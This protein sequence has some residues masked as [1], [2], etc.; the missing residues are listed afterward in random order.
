MA[1]PQAPAAGI[2]ELTKPVCPRC[3]GAV[4][5]Y[6]RYRKG[7]RVYLYAVHV[8]PDSGRRRK[9]YL[10]PVDGYV[11]ARTTHP[12]LSLRGF[13]QDVELDWDRRVDYVVELL[14]SFQNCHDD[15]VLGRLLENLRA[16][17]EILE[18]RISRV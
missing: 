12:M 11:H 1:K 10:G 3:G 5:W 2:S 6:E 13:A 15:D 8:D 7:G 18:K 17:A 16:Y 14:E 9:C 4:D